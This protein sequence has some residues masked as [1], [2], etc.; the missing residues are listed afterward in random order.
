MVEDTI[1]IL[2][3]KLQPILSPQ[4]DGTVKDTGV[5]EMP[6]ATTEYGQSIQAIN[7]RLYRSYRQLQDLNIQA[8]V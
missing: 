3:G 1:S 8:E 5:S 6:E 7:S 4:E 2:Q